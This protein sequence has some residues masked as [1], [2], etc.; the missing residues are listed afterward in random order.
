[1]KKIIYVLLF[2]F[3]LF[4]APAYALVTF[5]FESGNYHVVYINDLGTSTSCSNGASMN[6]DSTNIEYLKSF[7]KY[8]DAI[9]YM[10]TIKSLPNKTLVIIGEKKNTDGVYVNDILTSEYALVDLNTTGTTSTTSYVYKEET[11]NR[12]YTY[13]NGHGMFGGVDA[14][15]IDYSNEKSRAKM[16]IA[17]VTGWI[18]SILYLDAS[19]YDGFDIVPLSVVK[20]PSYYYVNG[21][22]EL[23][24]RLSR[25]ITANNCYATSLTLGPAPSSLKQKDENDNM[26]KYY[27]YDGIYFYT[28]LESMVND[29]KNGI[30]INAVNKIPYYNYYMYLPV[31]S[32]TNITSDNIK[33]YLESRNYTSKEKSVLYGEELTFIDAENKYGVNAITSF[34][35]AINESGWGTS[36]LARTKNNIFG[37]NAFDSSVMESASKYKNVSDGIYRHAYYMINAGFAETKDA[38]ARY[39]GS[40]LGNKNS[41]VNVKYAS[42][43]YWGEKIASYYYS[44][45]NYS[46]LKDYK[47]VKIGIKVT[48]TPVPV[49][50]E[51]NNSSLTLYKLESYYNDVSNMS[52][53]ILDK[54]AGEAIDG[55]S[56]WYKIQTDALLNEN[57][58]DLI[59][60]TTINDHYNWDNNYGYV[61]SSY[62][63]LMDE[64]VNNEYIKKDGLFALEELSLTEDKKIKIKGYLAITGMDNTIDKNITYDLIVENDNKS[65]SLPLERITDLSNINYKVPDKDY[66]YTYSWFTG[67]VDLKDI[68]EG[69]Y[70]LFIRARS[71][72]YESKEVLS[73]LFSK[74]TVSKYT[75]LNNKGYQ[76]RTNYYLKTI[77]IELFVRNN[78]LIND[79]VTPTSD[80]MIN[81]YQSISLENGLLKLYGSSFNVGGNYNT[82]VNVERSIIFENTTTY[83]RYKFDLGYIDNGEYKIT[84]LVPDNL[85]KTRAWFNKSIDISNLNKGT[86]A[87]YIETK[88]NVEDYG[89][90]NDIFQREIKSTMSCNDKTYSLKINDK[91]RFRVELEIK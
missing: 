75:D 21:S 82:S 18:D 84:L 53:V 77:P 20:S 26:I 24:H 8:D 19:G 79:K 62:I 34:S 43:P 7:D 65:F 59:R 56:T 36:Y 39:Y 31:R 49:K 74:K 30:N 85:D 70:N 76:F 73:D 15:L 1:M 71:G 6:Y 13:I 48:D 11:S 41:G 72:E 61:H 57:R 12:A 9:D 64:N 55:N 3:L 66:D 16:M 80:N 42:D 91:Q 38:V 10:K 22:N 81:Q 63:T 68:D 88:T 47:S 27:S 4:T 54:V 83:E 45:D 90:L 40:H 60:D 44:I 69:N 46:D 35:T 37:H 25:K 78:G 52:V 29:Y 50:K 87:I 67:I 23:V 17:G 58:D 32:K 5:N 28:S 2:M 14:A 51:A 89:E 86:Y 33:N